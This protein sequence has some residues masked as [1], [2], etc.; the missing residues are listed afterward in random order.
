[1]CSCGLRQIKERKAPAQQQGVALLPHSAH[2]T[3]GCIHQ[4]THAALSALAAVGPVNSFVK[5]L[6]AFPTTSY[7]WVCLVLVIR[8]ESVEFKC[9]LIF[10]FLL[11]LSFAA[12]LLCSRIILFSIF[13]K[14]I[15]ITN[16]QRHCVRVWSGVL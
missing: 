2:C 12:T 8:F 13:P 6:R 9:F 4:Y 11:W 1:M 10:T 3:Q 5:A 15:I 7:R 14:E 16:K